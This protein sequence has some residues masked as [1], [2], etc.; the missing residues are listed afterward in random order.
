PTLLMYCNSAQSTIRCCL[1]ASRSRSVARTESALWASSRPASACTLKTGS[2]EPIMA[3]LPKESRQFLES[4]LHAEVVA[5]IHA[6]VLHSIHQL[7]YQMYAESPR[8]ALFQRLG[9][10]RWQRQERVEFRRLVR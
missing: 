10:L 7:A 3:V 4:R 2:C 6:P 5:A 9:H 8:F 1:A